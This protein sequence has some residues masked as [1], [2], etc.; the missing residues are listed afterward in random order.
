M[1]FNFTNA[2]D[3]ILFPKSKYLPTSTISEIWPSHHAGCYINMFNLPPIYYNKQISKEH[4]E[5]SKN[6]SKSKTCTFIQKLVFHKKGYFTTFFRGRYFDLCHL[7]TSFWDRI[8]VC[9]I[10]VLLTKL[11]K[12][13]YSM[14]VEKLFS[15]EVLI[16]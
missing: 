15:R 6:F 1:F 8:V 11:W 9:A 5:L 2:T 16:I 4:Y 14:P 7:F 12:N 13:I 10:V 3:F